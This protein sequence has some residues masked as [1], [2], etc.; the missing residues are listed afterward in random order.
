V[1]EESIS[2]TD[3]SIDESSFKQM[4]DDQSGFL[5][6][7]PYAR[8]EFASLININAISKSAA[9]NGHTPHYSSHL[10]SQA[11]EDNG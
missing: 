8:I 7:C 2:V 9:S 10:C 4:L 1:Q 5:C 6:A 11:V 3:V